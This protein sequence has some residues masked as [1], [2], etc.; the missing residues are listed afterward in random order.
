MKKEDYVY[1]LTSLGSDGFHTSSAW[2]DLQRREGLL[3]KHCGRI[4]P[5]KVQ[6]PASFV[7][8]SKRPLRPHVGIPDGVNCCAILSETLIDLMIAD[9]LKQIGRLIPVVNPEGRVDN[10]HMVC[11][12]FQNDAGAI[13]GPAPHEPGVCKVCGL[14]SYWPGREPTE[15]YVLRRYWDGSRNFGCLSS[16]L[17]LKAE[18]YETVI[19]PLK[20]EKLRGRKVRL[21]DEPRDGLPADFQLLHEELR[22]RGAFR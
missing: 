20:L 13:R 10:T 17:I 6:S 12:S 18:Y 16:W 9:E 14:L 8:D 11:V 21:V 1:W 22:G 19:H 7:C 2:L 5:H 4:M 15:W 3:C